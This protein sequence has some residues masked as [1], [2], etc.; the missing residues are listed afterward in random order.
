[1]SGT[2]AALATARWPELEEPGVVLV[3]LGSTEQHGPH[4]PFS[5]DTTIAQAVAARVGER[6]REAGVAAVV[7]PALAYGA[8]GEHQGFPG[9]ASIGEEALAFLIVELARSL[10]AWAPRIVF[11]NAHGG[12]LRALADAVGQ[13][14]EEGHDV[15]WVPCGTAGG[16]AHAGRTET[17]IMLRLEPEAVAVAEAAAGATD[18]I[19]ALMPALRARGVRGVSANG[20]LGDPAGASAEEGAA[21]LAE[22]TDAALG[23]LAK[24]GLGTGRGTVSAAAPAAPETEE[25][26]A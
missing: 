11:V 20:V 16:D 6:L 1:M 2:P 4:L 14:Q 26:P 10:S 9:T 12:N 21:L 13:L 23:R 22:M 5:T 17:S 18:S 7:A 8:S 15:A 24:L 3:P 25:S 19:G